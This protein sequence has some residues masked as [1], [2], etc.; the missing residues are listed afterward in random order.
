MYR[1]SYAVDETQ[2]SVEILSLVFVLSFIID[3]NER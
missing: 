1:L 3:A 2:A